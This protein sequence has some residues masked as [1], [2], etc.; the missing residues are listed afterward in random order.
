MDVKGLRIF[1]IIHPCFM[2]IC[3]MRSNY[4]I[5]LFI[6]FWKFYLIPMRLW[7]HFVW[8]QYSCMENIMLISG[9]L[10]IS[11]TK[12]SSMKFMRGTASNEI[13]IGLC[14]TRTVGL[15]ELH[16]ENW[17]IKFNQRNSR[18]SNRR[19]FTGGPFTLWEIKLN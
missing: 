17:K 13:F 8:L 12:L 16:L 15:H 11:N 2:C 19:T 5:E 1:N 10:I 9:K 7:M 14:R 18:H 3:G 4:S 6:V